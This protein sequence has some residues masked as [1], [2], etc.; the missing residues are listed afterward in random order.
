MKDSFFMPTYIG[1]SGD[2]SLLFKDHPY[3]AH[4]PYLKEYYLIC[5]SYHAG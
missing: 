4:V 2:Y 3:A 5:A 1:G